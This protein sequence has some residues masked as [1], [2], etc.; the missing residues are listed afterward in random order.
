MIHPLLPVERR[1][2]DYGMDVIG[3]RC[4]AGSFMPDG[5]SEYS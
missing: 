4:V 1:E 5:A 2:I 3:F